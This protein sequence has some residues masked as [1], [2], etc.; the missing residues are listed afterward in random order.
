MCPE[1]L[2]EKRGE[3]TVDDEEKGQV[4]LRAQ[5]LQVLTWEETLLLRPGQ[6][7]GVG[8][9]SSRGPCQSPRLK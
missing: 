4:I 3:Q 2:G 5:E 8:D 1:S 6:G 9:E 7:V